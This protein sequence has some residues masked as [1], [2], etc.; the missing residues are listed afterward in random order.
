[1]ATSACGSTGCVAQITL[2]LEGGPTHGNVLRAIEFMG[3]YGGHVREEKR[4]EHDERIVFSIKDND[5][6]N[7]VEDGVS[8]AIAIQRQSTAESPYSRHIRCSGVVLLQAQLQRKNSSVA[9]ERRGLQIDR[10]SAHRFT[11]ARFKEQASMGRGVQLLIRVGPSAEEN[12]LPSGLRCH[13]K[14]A[15]RTLALSSVHTYL[16]PSRVTM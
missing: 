1:M 2:G 15:M 11:V 5:P 9:V 4:I 7:Y 10:D 12:K 13:E 8:L 3:K 16:S 14:A 6:K